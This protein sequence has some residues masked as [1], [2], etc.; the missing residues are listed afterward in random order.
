MELVRANMLV[1]GYS[2]SGNFAHE[3]EVSYLRILGFSKSEV[4]F[5]NEARFLRNS[6]IYYGKIL[7]EEYANTFYNFLDKTY[8]KLKEI[9]NKK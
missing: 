7:N 1:S 5:M 6:I 3:A 4:E 9:L 8:I 2:C